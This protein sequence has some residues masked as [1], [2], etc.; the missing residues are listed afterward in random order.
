MIN[1]IALAIVR[2]A[3]FLYLALGLFLAGNTLVSANDTLHTTLRSASQTEVTTFIID[4]LKWML[5]YT[6]SG[7]LVWALLML[8]ASAYDQLS[9]IWARH[10]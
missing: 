9:D 4:Q 1:Q 5:G 10:K 2:I 8:I 6:L 7:A 3:A